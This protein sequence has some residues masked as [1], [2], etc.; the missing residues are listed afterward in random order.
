M[1]QLNFCNLNKNLK[2]NIIKRM[3]EEVI[4][5]LNDFKNNDNENIYLYNDII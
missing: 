1:L 4:F 5:S 2:K 3:D